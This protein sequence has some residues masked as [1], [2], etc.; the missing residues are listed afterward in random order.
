MKSY[1]KFIIPCHLAFFK[2]YR[3]AARTGSTVTALKEEGLE[4]VKKVRR[5]QIKLGANCKWFVSG[6]C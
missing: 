4:P 2:I 5:N 3:L 1:S 6:L